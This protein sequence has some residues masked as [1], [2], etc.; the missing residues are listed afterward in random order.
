MMGSSKDHPDRSL[1]QLHTESMV[2]EE[3]LFVDG[4]ICLWTDCEI[5]SYYDFSVAH[6]V[7]L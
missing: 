4:H 7:S 2:L 5:D 6:L 1:Q 3:E